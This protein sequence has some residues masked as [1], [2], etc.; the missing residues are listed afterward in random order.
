MLNRKKKKTLKSDSNRCISTRYH[1]SDAPKSNPQTWETHTMKPPPHFV[2]TIPERLRSS[3]LLWKVFLFLVFVYNNY[4]CVC[5]CVSSFLSVFNFIF[6]IF[7]FL[8]TNVVSSV[9][10]VWLPAFGCI[11]VTCPFRSWSG[12]LFVSLCWSF[13]SLLLLT[14]LCSRSRFLV[15]DVNI[16]LS[17]LCSRTV[18][19]LWG[20][21]GFPTVVFWCS[22]D[23]MKRK[24][25]ETAALLL[26]LSSSS[27]Q[28]FSIWVTTAQT[29]LNTLFLL[30]R[31]RRGPSLPPNTPRPHG[32]DLYFAADQLFY[33][34]QTQGRVAA[35]AHAGSRAKNAGIY[36]AF[37]GLICSFNT[38]N[39]VWLQSW[40]MVNY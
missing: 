20:S 1:A 21:P 16:S 29:V 36:S 17:S 40:S 30:S 9:S 37:V 26:L 31:L 35:S 3:E 27:S 24:S 23:L 32:P 34:R 8:W 25:L 2:F 38:F 14:V 28:I 10:F 4:F 6:Y 19:R 5:L 22:F 7:S 12:W 15:L 13:P 11:L 18:V 33:C 39:S